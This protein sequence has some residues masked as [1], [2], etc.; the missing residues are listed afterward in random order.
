MRQFFYLNKKKGNISI[1]KIKMQSLNYY[2]YF[3]M[4]KIFSK[5]LES[6]KEK[7]EAL[8]VLMYQKMRFFTNDGEKL[9][10]SS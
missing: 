1:C 6:F 4:F 7:S 8:L 10:K 3:C 5:N 2:I 9:E